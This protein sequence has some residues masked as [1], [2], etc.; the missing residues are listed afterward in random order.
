[1]KQQP[2]S[3]QN[4]GLAVQPGNEILSILL[5]PDGLS[6]AFFEQGEMR[7]GT[8]K[9]PADRPE[10]GFDFV[11]SSAEWPRSAFAK[12]W[13]CV[14][15]E[16]AVLVPEALDQ[17]EKYGRIVASLGYPEDPGAC[18]LSLPCPGNKVL[19]HA[20]C[21][22]VLLPLSEKYGE[23]LSFFHPLYAGLCR[24]PK[25]KGTVLEVNCAGGYV[26]FTLTNGQELL[27]ADVFPATR[28]ADLL[29]AVNR[30]VVT[31]KISSFHVVCS[32]DRAEENATLLGRHYRPVS[33]HPDGENRNLFFPF[34]CE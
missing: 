6:F 27:W 20:V 10:A 9:L 18:L 25:E 19:L 24:Q 23:A 14:P 16:C 34:S 15:A 26:N 12:V 17:P 4:H 7:S 1:M 2:V 31:G 21:K 3:E 8:I 22:E 29:L 13:V 33:V 5:R 30:I 32:G 11:F 28:K